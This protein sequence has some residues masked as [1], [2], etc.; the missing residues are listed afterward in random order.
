MKVSQA[1]AVYRRIGDALKQKWTG[2][3]AFVFT[4][5]AEAAKS[6]GLRPSKNSA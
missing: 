6:F 1:A 3:T 4:G 2:W 5:N